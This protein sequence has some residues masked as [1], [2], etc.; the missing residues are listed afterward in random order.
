[1]PVPSPPDDEVRHDDERLPAIL[2]GGYLRE[3][4]VTEG[5]PAAPEDEP[6]APVGTGTNARI[7]RS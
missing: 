6:A 5:L 4:P 7:A 3:L 1:V 2:R